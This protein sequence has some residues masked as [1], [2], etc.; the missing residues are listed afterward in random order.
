MESHKDCEHLS[1][2]DLIKV[3]CNGVLRYDWLGK[4]GFIA[5]N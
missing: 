4:W 5:S 2:Q 3:C 1:R